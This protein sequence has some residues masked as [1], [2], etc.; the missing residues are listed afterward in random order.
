[1]SLSREAPIWRLLVTH[2]GNFLAMQVGGYYNLI[3]QK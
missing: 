1:M 3:M 2:L